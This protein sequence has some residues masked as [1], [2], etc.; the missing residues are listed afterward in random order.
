MNTKGHKETLWGNG[1]IP[2]VDYDDGYKNVY[3]CQKALNIFTCNLCISLYVNNILI[4]KSQIE[5]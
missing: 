4:F 1:N 3:M 2:C 5:I